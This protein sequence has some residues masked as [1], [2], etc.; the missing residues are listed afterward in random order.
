MTM[1]NSNDEQQPILTDEVDVVMEFTD[2]PQLVPLANPKRL[3][4]KSDEV[5]R[6]AGT[7]EQPQS[8]AAPATVD[9]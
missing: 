5:I 4:V 6:G 9:G 1:P 2:A 8:P 3:L 7:P